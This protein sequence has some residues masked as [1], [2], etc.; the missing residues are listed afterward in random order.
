MILPYVIWI[1]KADDLL[2]TKRSGEGVDD[3]EPMPW[4]DWYDQEASVEY[5]VNMA[6]EEIGAC[7]GLPG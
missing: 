4:R 6:L 7:P 5:A 2:R 1:M 3:I